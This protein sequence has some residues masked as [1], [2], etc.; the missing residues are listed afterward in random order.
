MSTNPYAT[1]KAQV[2][3]ETVVNLGRFVPGGRRVA[4]SRGWEW[5]ADGWRLFK[6]EPWT[7]IAIVIVFFVIFLVLAFIPFVG[8]LA[9]FVLTPVLTGGLMLGCHAI[10]QDGD[11]TIGHLFAGFG[12]RFGRLAA[13]GALYLAGWIVIFLIAM[14][15]TGASMFPLLGGGAVDI[16]AV[17][18]GAALAFLVMMALAV[19]LVMAVWFAPALVVFHDLSAV[20][21]LKQSFVGCLRN[22]VPFLVYG[23]VGLVLGIAASIPLGLGW[24]VLVPVIFCSIYA[25]Y[26]DVYFLG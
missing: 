1:P 16:F 14:V 15:V 23:V 2:A 5:I 4:A 24:L 22:V 6:R 17:V 8:G 10:D 12:E 18:A 7:W 3:D 11:L 13:V 20:E 21:A 19:P 25:S 26:R 9:Q